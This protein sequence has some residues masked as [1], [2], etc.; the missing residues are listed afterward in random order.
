MPRPRGTAY[1]ASLPLGGRWIGAERGT[2]RDKTDEAFLNFPFQSLIRQTVEASPLRYIRCLH[3]MLT[4][5][6]QGEG[7]EQNDIHLLGTR[8]GS[9]G[10][11]ASP[12]GRGGSA[13]PRRRGLVSPLC[14]LSHAVACQLPPEGEPRSEWCAPRAFPFGEWG[15]TSQATCG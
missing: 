9:I 6:S 1:L 3:L 10:L 13:K 15:R 11:Y 12:L 14:P 5:F 7:K 2:L 8:D 4:P